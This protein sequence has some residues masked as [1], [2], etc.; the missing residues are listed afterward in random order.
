M[1]FVKG[2]VNY[3]KY[4]LNKHDGM[5]VSVVETDVETGVEISIE[6]GIKSVFFFFFFNGCCGQCLDLAVVWFL[7]LVVAW[8]LVSYRCCGGFLVVLV[9]AVVFDGCPSGYGVVGFDLGLILS[10]DSH[11]GC[12]C[13]L[14]SFLVVALWIYGWRWWWILWVLFMVVGWVFFTVVVMGG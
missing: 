12:D 3:L 10:F 2:L 5:E 6:T 8:W 1:R 11:H 9:V 14:V 4:V 13:C 7:G